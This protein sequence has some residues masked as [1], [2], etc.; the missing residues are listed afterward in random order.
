MILCPTPEELRK[1]YQTILVNGTTVILNIKEDILK[2]LKYIHINELNGLV[3][4]LENDPSGFCD[5]LNK[6]EINSDDE[7]FYTYSKADDAEDFRAA[8]QIAYN[9][10][11]KQGQ[12]SD[13]IKLAIALS[14][15]QK[16]KYVST[17]PALALLPGSLKIKFTPCF[18]RSTKLFKTIYSLLKASDPLV[19]A[20]YALKGGLWLIAFVLEPNKSPETAIKQ[21][22][23]DEATKGNISWT[24]LDEN[25]DPKTITAKKGIIILL[26]G[27][28]STDVGTFE[29]FVD[30]WNDKL[31]DYVCKSDDFAILGWPHDTLAG[32]DENAKELSGLVEKLKVCELP[33]AFVC[34][35]RG[36]LVARRTIVYLKQQ[37]YPIEKLAWLSFGT[38]HKG[39]EFAECGPEEFAGILYMFTALFM[40]GEKSPIALF[41]V[42]RYYWGGGTFAGVENLRPPKNEYSFFGL[43]KKNFIAD[44]QNSEKVVYRK[45]DHLKVKSYAVS[46]SWISSGKSNEKLFEYVLEHLDK[47]YFGDKTK[48]DGIVSVESAKPD[49]Y[50]GSDSPLSCMHTEYFEKDSICK[51]EFKS[52][53]EYLTEKFFQCQ[54][55]EGGGGIWKDI[56]YE[57][58]DGKIYLSGKYGIGGDHVKINPQIVEEHDNFNCIRDGEFWCC[59]EGKDVDEYLICLGEPP[60]WTTHSIK[61]YYS[62][63]GEEIYL[64]T[65]IED[66]LVKPRFQH[67]FV[68]GDNFHC[69]KIDEVWRC[70]KGDDINTYLEFRGGEPPKWAIQIEESYYEV[71]GGEIYLHSPIVLVRRAKATPRPEKIE[72]NNGNFHCTQ[73]KDGVWRCGYGD[74][75]NKYLECIGGEPPKWAIQE[76]KLDSSNPNQQI[77]DDK[78]E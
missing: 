69:K 37:K 66:S 7:I 27:V 18:S 48:N 71:Q 38:P 11:H 62:A 42:L 13:K 12:S 63:L 17:W 45:L 67:P 10:W 31:K 68:K 55:N 59:G 2:F 32:I 54:K 77:P 74:D 35:S 20:A 24:T 1:D 34:H 28:F 9:I 4:S 51:S 57:V 53:L 25:F 65:M 26:H 60:D 40:I 52:A 70:G 39:S 49:G 47:I 36:G 78:A 44:L 76:D 75:I 43:K 33:I 19:K 3:E 16:I 15:K 14:S 5:T 8:L 41:Q 30:A 50:E 56:Y 61:Y 23:R 58:I 46:G 29:G 72:Q 6:I 22:V 21:L 73:V 64:N